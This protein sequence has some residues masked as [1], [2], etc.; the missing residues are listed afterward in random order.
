MESART[1]YEHPEG[2]IAITAAL[3]SP[4]GDY[5]EGLALGNLFWKHG[6]ATLVQTGA[7]CCY[8][9]AATALLGGAYLGARLAAAARI[10]SSS[11]V[12]PLD[13]YSFYSESSEMTRDEWN[14]AWEALVDVPGR[15]RD[16]T[17]YRYD[18]ASREFEE[19]TRGAPL[20]ETVGQFRKLGVQLR[21]TERRHVF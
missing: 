18:F 4:G 12:G 17:A 11:W 10:G 16:R 1:E 15:L 21:G 14:R 13:L 6:Y 3:N 2:P 7:E 20:L 19:G 8:S 9:A 5:L